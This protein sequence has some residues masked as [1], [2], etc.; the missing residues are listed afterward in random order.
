MT[1]GVRGE[2]APKQRVDYGRVDHMTEVRRCDYMWRSDAAMREA[3]AT[4]TVALRE[5]LAKESRDAMRVTN[6][7]GIQC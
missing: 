2:A 3:L 1:K 7:E 6:T 5:R 4:E